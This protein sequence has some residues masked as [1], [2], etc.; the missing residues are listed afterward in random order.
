MFH[1]FS[2]EMKIPYYANLQDE[3][4]LEHL[5]CFP[6]NYIREILVD[7]AENAFT[8]RAT[9]NSWDIPQPSKWWIDG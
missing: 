6:Y 2:S 3:S 1:D 9:I 5:L 4:H 8:Y 7:A